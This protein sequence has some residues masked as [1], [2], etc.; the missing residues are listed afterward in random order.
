MNLTFEKVLP[1]ASQL[2]LL[3]AMKFLA[4][5]GHCKSIAAARCLSYATAR[6]L[7]YATAHCRAMLRSVQEHAATRCAS[8]HRLGAVCTRV[9]AL[10]HTAAENYQTAQTSRGMLMS[11]LHAGLTTCIYRL[12]HVHALQPPQLGRLCM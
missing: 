5:M 7:S 1:I 12:K 11:A 6:C 2:L 4:P 8:S 10:A 9:E 3:I